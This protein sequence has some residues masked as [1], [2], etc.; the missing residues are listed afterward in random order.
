MEEIE[1]A[2]A[3]YRTR[4]TREKGLCDE[5]HVMYHTEQPVG[6]FKRP[7]PQS[8]QDLQERV[9]EDID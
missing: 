1:M 9:R 8:G 7:I 4:F 3:V 2:E 5:T 6:C